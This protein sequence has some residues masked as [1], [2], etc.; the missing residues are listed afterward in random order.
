MAAAASTDGPKTTQ[1]GSN[2]TSQLVKY[3]IPNWA[4]RPP[5]GFHLDVVKGEQLVQ[6]N[7]ESGIVSDFSSIS[8]YLQ[9]LM[10]DEKRAYYF[11]R[12]PEQCDFVVEHASCSRVH[13]VLIYH[14]FLQRFGLVDLNSCHGTFVGKMRLEP[15]Q[16]VF[17][18]EGNIFHFGASTRRYILR[19]R[20]GVLDEDEDGNK[21]VLPQE[22]E[23]ENLTEY[24]TALNRRIQVIPISLEDARRKKR[25]R[26]NVSFLEEETIINPEDVDPT[27]G[28]FRNLVTTAII[29]S[30]RKGMTEESGDAE[31]EGPAPKKI[32]R[33]GRIDDSKN[34]ARYFL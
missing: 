26:G 21:D 28:R 23:L 20:L 13:A 6:V 9:K 4:G 11:G 31:K 14:R 18:E 30:K 22:H 1:E 12:N 32:L 33:P 19:G 27:I 15:Y 2:T 10:V 29:S 16:P 17:I 5:N 34:P 8:T 25:Q 7:E 24:N 3:D